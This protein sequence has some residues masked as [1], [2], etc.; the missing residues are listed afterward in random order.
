[1][2]LKRSICSG[3]GQGLWTRF[4][5]VNYAFAMRSPEASAA[6]TISASRSNK[7][8][9]QAARDHHRSVSYGAGRRG[10]SPGALQER[11]H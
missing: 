5:E 8:R 3:L 7:R 10:C 6:E 11:A 4:G 9:G 1:M 2:M